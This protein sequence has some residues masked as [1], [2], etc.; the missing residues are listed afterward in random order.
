MVAAE[1]EEPDEDECLADLEVDGEEVPGQAPA[2]GAEGAEDEDLPFTARI[3][4]GKDVMGYVKQLAPPEM[5]LVV[6]TFY[7]FQEMRKRAGNQVYSLKKRKKGH[8]FLFWLMGCGKRLEA[9]IAKAL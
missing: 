7:L 1:E 9:E 4:L 8:A 2:E 5:R 6:Y 3:K